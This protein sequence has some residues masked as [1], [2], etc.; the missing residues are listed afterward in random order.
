MQGQALFGDVGAGGHHGGHGVALIQGLLVG[1]Y[2]FSHQTHI[3]LGLGEVDDLVLDDGEVLRGDRAHNAGKSLGT[4]G[5]YGADAGMGVGA[6]QY[7]AV[8]HPGQ[9]DVGAVLGC[10][11]H[12]VNT[13]VADWPS[14]DD[15]VLAAG[16]LL[17]GG[18][19]YLRH[20]CVSQG[21][22]A[23]KLAFTIATTP[24]LSNAIRFLGDAQGIKRKFNSVNPLQSEKLPPIQRFVVQ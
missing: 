18:H 10:T 16:A 5:V 21:G 4:A 17:G 24:G 7:L 20:I 14:A 2:V 13:V 6:A 8:Q 19:L 15:L 9:L 11:S 23:C 12:L 3:A 1:H 22:S